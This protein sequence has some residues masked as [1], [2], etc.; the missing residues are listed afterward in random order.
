MKKAIA[1]LAIV[2]L[3]LL[4]L[5][6]L[7]FWNGTRARHFSGP[8]SSTRIRVHVT[9]TD[10]A[11]WNPGSDF[12]TDVSLTTTNWDSM[13]WY[14]GKS[15]S[16]ENVH[17]LLTSMTWLDGT[18]LQFDCHNGKTVRIHYAGDLWNVKESRMSNTNQS[19]HA[20][21][22]PAQGVASSAHEG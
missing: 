1:I 19:L 8:D 11:S 21:S 4:V 9:V 14:A 16:I 17:K 6:L 15:D 3:S 2:V 10:A 20:P 13:T 7:P 18:T 22:K 12:Y 5:I